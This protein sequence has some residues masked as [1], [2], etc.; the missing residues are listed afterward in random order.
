M[1]ALHFTPLFSRFPSELM[2]WKKVFQSD[3]PD[4]PTLTRFRL[5]NGF[6]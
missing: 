6:S 3:A 1:V 5:L 2:G 4:V